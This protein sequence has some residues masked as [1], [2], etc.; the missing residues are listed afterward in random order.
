M[1]ELTGRGS[2]GPFRSGDSKVGSADNRADLTL[3][4]ACG[5]ATMGVV[6]VIIDIK[7][8]QRFAH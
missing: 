4:S 5:A 3:H 8:Q 7:D 2:R 6:C 1:H